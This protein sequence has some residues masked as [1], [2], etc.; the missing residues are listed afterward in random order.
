MFVPISYES[1]R[2]REQGFQVMHA[3]AVICARGS[4]QRSSGCQPTTRR[5]VVEALLRRVAT[6][7]SALLG[8]LLLCCGI[9]ANAQSPEFERDY[10]ISAEDVLEISV[11]KEPDLQRE[12]TVRPDGGVSFPLAGNILAA[13]LTP[14]E[15]EASI[16]KLLVAYIPDAVV[17]V[18]VIDIQGLRVYVSGKV[19]NPGQF[20]VG[21]YVDV[22]QALTLAGGLTP[23]A[24]EKNIQVIRH[25][26]NGDQV[27][28]FNYA[29][30]KKGKKIAAEHRSS[31]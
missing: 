8:T 10:R 20:V 17:S 6:T 18:S 15:L 16:T 3:Y 19:Q 2:R 21:R 11:W 14:K 24:D 22:L 12:V 26:P 5:L 29:Q 7:I 4:M 28:K 13:G 30:V 27:F 9:A 31:N 23:F 1:G 25:T